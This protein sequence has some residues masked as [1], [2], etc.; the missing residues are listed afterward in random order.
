MGAEQVDLLIALI[1]AHELRQAALGDVDAQHI[2]NGIAEIR[3]QHPAQRK[4]PTVEIGVEE[5]G[6]KHV[7]PS[8]RD[9]LTVPFRI[10]FGLRRRKKQRRCQALGI[11]GVDP[12][13]GLGAGDDQLRG[14]LVRQ[15]VHLVLL[16][17]GQRSVL[18][19]A[20]E[21]FQ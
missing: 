8:G 10:A 4:F 19:I 2:R 9:D 16:G 3:D 5:Y 20:V 7:I 12:V 11:I 14:V 1:L 18:I 13:P 6:T 15:R 21:K 17:C